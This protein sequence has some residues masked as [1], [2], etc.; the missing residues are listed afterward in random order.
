MHILIVNW[1]DITHPWAGG[2]ERHIHEL[3]KQ[4][5]ML[6]HSVTILAGGYA[7]AISC[8]ILDGITIER[9][10]NTYTIYLL[11]FWVYLCKYRFRNYDLVIET[12]HGLPFFFRLLGGNIALI[13]HHNHTRLWFSEWPKIVAVIGSFIERNIVP[14][15][16]RTVPVITLSEKTKDDLVKSGFTRVTAVAPG[17]HFVKSA[18]V[19]KFEIPTIISIGRLRRYKRIDLLLDVMPTIASRIP[20]VRLIIAGNGQDRARI[21]R[22]IRTKNLEK[23]VELKGFVSEEEKHELL[24]RAWVFAFPSLIEGW[25]L[26]ALEAS[27]S[28]TP[29]VGF[30]VPGVSDAVNDGVS[31][32]LANTKQEFTDAIVKILKVKSLR[33]I[34]NRGAKHWAKQFT[35]K[36]SAE[37]FL[38]ATGE[39]KKRAYDVRY[40]T[41]YWRTAGARWFHPVY[42]IRVWFLKKLSGNGKILDVGCGSG[43]IVS[44]LRK[45][46]VNAWGI[47]ANKSAFL[48]APKQVLPYLRIGRAQHL[49]CKDKSF[50]VVSCIDVF[51]H[52]QQS[53]IPGVIRECARVAKRYVYFDI[54]GLEDFFYIHTDPAHINKH[55]SWQWGNMIAQ[56]LGSGWIVRRPFIIPFLHHSIFLAERK[57]SDE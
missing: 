17:I 44:L 55:Y 3:A 15:M 35:W 19:K 21:E 29:T 31:G 6:G 23:F 42:D 14:I 53:D 52:I 28:G 46:R 43:Y 57:A 51:E 54:T 40:F 50:K 48:V 27:A 56:T 5:V 10:G 47:D 1:R 18:T 38:E 12:A 36:S 25:G 37:R 8:E 41:D 13:I 7:D 11:A 24:S 32:I 34:L 16:Y 39:R 9:I 30:N 45:K 22:L 4:W 26:V 20:R 33:G 2:A 49:P